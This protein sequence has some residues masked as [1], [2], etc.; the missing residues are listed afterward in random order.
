VLLFFGSAVSLVSALNDSVVT[1]ESGTYTLDKQEQPL[2][3]AAGLTSDPGT[4]LDIVLTLTAASAAAG[5]VG[6]RVSY[7]D[8]GG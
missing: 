1:N 3:Q 7:L 4:T 2:W 5:K 8:N 6:L